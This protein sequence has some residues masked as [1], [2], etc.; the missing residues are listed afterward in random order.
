MPGEVEGIAWRWR[1]IPESEKKGGSK[2]GM[3]GCKEEE[4]NVEQ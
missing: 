3:T 1:E 4:C 2:R